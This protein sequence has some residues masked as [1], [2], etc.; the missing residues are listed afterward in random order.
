[1]FKGS[2]TFYNAMYVVGFALMMVWN[3]KDHKRYGIQKRDA[4]LATVYTY[5]CGIAGALLMGFIYNKVNAALGYSGGSNVA[6]FGAVV[7]TPFLLL[8]FPIKHRQWKSIMDMLAP[9]ILLILTCAKF[10]CFINGCCVGIVCDFGLHYRSATDKFFPVQ[11]FEVVTMLLVLLFTQLYVRKT[12]RF[13]AGTAYPITFAAYSVTRFFWEFFRYYAKDGM[14]HMI[15]GMTFWQ[16]V[17]CL[18]FVVCVTIVA[19]LTA[20]AKK[21][22]QPAQPDPAQPEEE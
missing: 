13:V 11:I 2:E 6:I 12:K 22:P 15:L 17:C 10:G 20:K 7:F 1:M 5:I 8:I 14:R 18:T 21:Q 4:V 16:F 19:A 3:L 9:G